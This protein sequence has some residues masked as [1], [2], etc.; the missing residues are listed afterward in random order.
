MTYALWRY[1]DKQIEMKDKDLYF[2]GACSSCDC[3][4]YA[5]D[6][7]INCADCK[8]P[9]SRHRISY[10]G[11]RL[12]TPAPSKPKEYYLKS[13]NSFNWISFQWLTVLNPFY[14]LTLTW[15]ALGWLKFPSLR[16]SKGQKPYVD[17]KASVIRHINRMAV[18]I[19]HETPRLSSDLVRTIPDLTNI[20][21]IDQNLPIVHEFQK[22]LSLAL[23]TLCALV[24]LGILG[25]RGG[26]LNFQVVNELYGCKKYKIKASCINILDFSSSVITLCL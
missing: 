3:P 18:K 26:H 1:I 15:T 13:I 11:Q 4:E 12:M 14:W 6:G 10:W 7:R 21:D 8:C 19:L 25:F 16:M 20:S 17:Y 2:R 24:I 22:R 23:P 5:N 9:A